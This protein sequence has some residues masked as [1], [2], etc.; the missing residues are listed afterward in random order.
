MMYQMPMWQMLN[1]DA[2]IILQDHLPNLSRSHS[3]RLS[4]SKKCKAT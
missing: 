4:I 2:T 1:S 3:Y